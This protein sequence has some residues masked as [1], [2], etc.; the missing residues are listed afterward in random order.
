MQK[1][2]RVIGP[3]HRPEALPRPKPL[4]G[5]L[6]LVGD[7]NQLS[8]NAICVAWYIH[9]EQIASRSINLIVEHRWWKVCATAAVED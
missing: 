4:H 2:K 6:E 1:E 5:L 3:D 8:A 7:W 9:A